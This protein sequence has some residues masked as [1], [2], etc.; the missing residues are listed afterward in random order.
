MAINIQIAKHAVAFPT[1]VLAKKNAKHTLNI[2][3]TKDHDN[4]QFV[5]IG[6]FVS[7]DLY[8][9]GAVPNDFKAVVLGQAKNGRWYVGVRSE[10]NNVVF[11]YDPEIM[12]E[13]NY[14][15]KFADPANFYHE[16]GE[17][18]TGI[19]PAM[20]DTVEVSDK[21]FVGTPKKDA[22]LTLDAATGKLK[23]VTPKTGA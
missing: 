10:N 7:L 13:S 19:I 15:K 6:E 16:T 5:G 2:E 14:G 8:K 4:G 9:E 21:G 18:V 17:V 3:L 11:I 12:A 22:E 1:N 20:Y 23:V